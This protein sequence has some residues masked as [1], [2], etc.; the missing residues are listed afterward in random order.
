[1]TAPTR[2]RLPFGSLTVT[3]H[4]DER[5]WRI[6]NENLILLAEAGSNLHGIAVGSDDRDQM[7]V[8]I[9]PPEVLLGV[10]K[11]ELYEYRTQPKGVRSGRNDLDLN[12]YGLTKWARLVMDGNPTHLLPLFAPDDKLYYVDGPGKTLRNH[13][14]LFVAREHGYRFLGYLNQQRRHL[15]GELEPRTNRPELIEEYG[16]DTK[17]GSHAMRIAMQGTE[18]MRTGRI[19][20]PMADNER[21]FLIGVREGS[22]TLDEGLDHITLLEN[23]LMAAMKASPLQPYPDYDRLNALLVRLY[24]EWWSTR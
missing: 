14:H 6:A 8:C 7:G 2:Y 10:S 5:C 1:M 24:Q 19:T 4:S 13:A 12:V 18:L 21:E 11:F 9:E 17:Y 16:W 3:P 22:M 15:I 23:D 20:L